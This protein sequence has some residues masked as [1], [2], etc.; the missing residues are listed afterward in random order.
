MR[1][2]WRRHIEILSPVATRYLALAILIVN[3]LHTE[4]M[5]FRE[6]GQSVVW[7][8]VEILRERTTRKISYHMS[9]ALLPSSTEKKLMLI[10]KVK[11]N[12][13]FHFWAFS[14]RHIQENVLPGNLRGNSR[15]VRLIFDKTSEKIKIPSGIDSEQKSILL[16]F[17]LAGGSSRYKRWKSITNTENH[18]QN[19]KR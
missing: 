10:R 8:A 18:S 2:Q 6:L 15:A 12:P 5:H 17:P 3:C 4:V 13:P 9:I 1:F 16:F 7:W 14:S 11:V 19:N